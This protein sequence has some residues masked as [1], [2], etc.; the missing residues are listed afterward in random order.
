MSQSTSRTSGTELPSAEELF[1]ILDKESPRKAVKF[2]FLE[3]HDSIFDIHRQLSHLASSN[4]EWTQDYP[5]MPLDELVAAI[6]KNHAELAAYI[7]ADQYEYIPK[8][9]S[10]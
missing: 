3:N 6:N 9:R 8:S 7:K 2:D 5:A 10:R 4:D 1:A